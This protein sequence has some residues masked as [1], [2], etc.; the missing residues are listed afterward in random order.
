MSNGMFWYLFVLHWKRDQTMRHSCCTYE[1]GEAG[2]MPVVPFSRCVR[3][4]FSSFFPSHS[5][6]FLELDWMNKAENIVLLNNVVK[7]M[8]LLLWGKNILVMSLNLCSYRP[9]FV[10]CHCQAH[11]HNAQ[12][13]WYLDLRSLLIIRDSS[14]LTSGFF[15][16]VL[17]HWLK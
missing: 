4:Y 13:L 17:P 7:N 10:Y 11:C 1:E 14:G 9:Y 3:C 2:W 8:L 5:R 16:F 12:T 6:Y 15:S